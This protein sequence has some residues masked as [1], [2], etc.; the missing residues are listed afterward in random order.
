MRSKEVLEGQIWSFGSYESQTA[1]ETLTREETASTLCCD[2]GTV[3]SL[4]S[5]AAAGGPLLRY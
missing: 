3:Q 1:W 5:S 4:P 2:V